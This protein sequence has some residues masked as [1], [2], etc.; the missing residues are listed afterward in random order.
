MSLQVIWSPASKEEYAVILGFIEDN[1]GENAALKFLDK[2]DTVIDGIATFP[3]MFPPSKLRKDV[4]KAV[5][6]KHTSVYYR[7]NR[8]E[9]Q[10]LHF[11]DNRQNP[12]SL[13]EIIPAT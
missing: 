2:T 5:I 3:S 11:W 9:V 12:E 1:F 8:E 10:L 7:Y 13:E 6:T 4:R